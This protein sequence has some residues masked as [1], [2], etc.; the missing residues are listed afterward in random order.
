MDTTSLLK[1]LISYRPVTDDVTQV[2]K[3]VDFVKQYLDDKGV[4]TAVEKSGSRKILYASVNDTKKPRIMFNSHLDVVPAE[5]N[6]FTLT[7]NDGWLYGRGTHDCLGNTAILIKLLVKSEP[8][9]DFGVIFST[10]EE[11]GGLT[12]A[13]MV[14]R[15][16]QAD[17]MVVIV[18]GSGDSIITAQKGVLSLQLKAIG[19]ECHAAKPW[20]GENAIDR[21][22]NGYLK[23]RELFPEV[24]PPDD[25]HNT[26]AATVINGGNVHN[27]VPEESCLTLNIRYTENTNA[28]DIVADIKR[29][30]GLEAEI[31]M[32]VPP[33]FCNRNST[34]IKKLE[35][36]M[37]NHLQREIDFKHSN[38]A[39][40]A[41]HFNNSGVP[42]A[43]IG[44]PGK[45]EHGSRECISIAG[46][47]EYE[48]MLQ[49]FPS[50]L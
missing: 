19:S 35:Q 7:E 49:Q 41:R 40:D 29:L 30:S 12:T 42:V 28:E 46:L 39:T 25:W 50:V 17:E 20:Q 33:V 21:L 47:K 14:K 31:N 16:Y 10:D 34:P 38:G 32:N 37:C 43:I 18:D 3:L 24:K 22:I 1:T 26:M 6:Q 15:G 2:N 5:E 11:Q 8:E 4:G 23:I 13:E 27:R 9:A 48:E 36:H 45:D 44:T